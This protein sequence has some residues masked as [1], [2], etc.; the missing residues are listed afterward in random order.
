VFKAFDFSTSEILDWEIKQI[1]HALLTEQ[2][3]IVRHALDAAEDDNIQP[4]ELLKAVL[5]GVPISKDLPNNGLNRKPG[6]NY[7]HRL[8]DGRWIRVK[9]A[10]IGQYAVITVYEI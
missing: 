5:V 4:V 7:E 1:D 6:I 10:W 8:E 9:V 2:I 3:I